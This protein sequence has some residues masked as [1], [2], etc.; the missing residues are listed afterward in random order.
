MQ[1]E[2]LVPQ[3]DSPAD[4]TLV[5]GV[6]QDICLG[7]D[8]SDASGLEVSRNNRHVS[9]HRKGFQEMQGLDR[10][11][12]FIPGLARHAG[13]RTRRTSRVPDSLVNLKRPPPTGSVCQCSPR[14]TSQM[15]GGS[16]VRLGCIP[17]HCLMGEKIV[18]TS[19]M[20]D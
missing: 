11:P 10:E 18:A 6:P 8:V 14:L 2:H 16:Y 15:D 7:A 20:T 4:E 3:P 5:G 1:Q 9:S 19:T 12:I 13:T 17:F